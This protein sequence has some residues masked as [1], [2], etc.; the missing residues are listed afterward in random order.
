MRAAGLSYR[1]IGRTLGLTSNQ[2]SRIRRVLKRAKAARTRLRT[3][4]P[5]ATERDLPISQTDLPAGL[6]Q[7]LKQAGLHTLGDLADRLADPAFPGLETLA[8]IGPHRAR[9]AK[10]LLDH[11]GLLPGS[12]DIQAEIEALFP[13]FG[14]GPPAAPAKRPGGRPAGP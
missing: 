14:D 2:L 11:H 13:E 5:Q 8:S 4:D 10:A 6:R 9:L 12:D 7:R 3:K 1:E